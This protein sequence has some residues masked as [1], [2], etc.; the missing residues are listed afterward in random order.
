M[1]NPNGRWAVKKVQ[2]ILP[3]QKT[4][5]SKIFETG[6]G[7]D[8]PA[9]MKMCKSVPKLNLNSFQKSAN[10]SRDMSHRNGSLKL[11]YGA[12]DNF[13][14]FKGIKIV[15]T[16]KM[17]NYNLNKQQKENM[18]SEFTAIFQG[19]VAKTDSYPKDSLHKVIN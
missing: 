15:D 19:K 4:E 14:D 18:I 11:S 12:D 8:V 7:V 10:T 5:M 6:M 13:S 1:K 2:I 16:S 17:L 3:A 9:T